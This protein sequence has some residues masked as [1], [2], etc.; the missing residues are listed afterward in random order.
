MVVSDLVKAKLG[1]LRLVKP[2]ELELMLSWRNA[3]N[4]RANMYNRHEIS[5][6]E[7]LAWWVGVRGR[8]DQRYFMYVSNKE[9]LG[10]VAFNSLDMVSQNSSWA[11]YAS[12]AA[13]KGTGSKME[14]LA[15]DYA[16]KE[17]KL[18]K[19]Y[20]EV[21]DFNTP[22]IRLHEKF[23]FKIE[24]VL[25]EQ[26]RY[27]NQYVAIYRLGML[28]TEWDV[29]RDALLAKLLQLKTSKT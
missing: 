13:T 14:F 12:P 28:A 27:E 22:V 26:H 8:T 10:I 18:H 1:E 11:F 3:P 9:P 4:V 20:C 23:G 24:G 21:L 7:H 2:D 29:N 19:L 25:R 6:T 15:L 17:L 5:L 16:F